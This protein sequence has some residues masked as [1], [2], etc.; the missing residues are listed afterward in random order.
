[1]LPAEVVE[2][3]HHQLQPVLAQR[4]VL[5]RFSIC[6]PELRLTMFHLTEAEEDATDLAL[7]LA[8]LLALRL[9]R[10]FSLPPPHWEVQESRLAFQLRPRATAHHHRGSTPPLLSLLFH[11]CVHH[12]LPLLLR[13]PVVHHLSRTHER[14]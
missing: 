12:R 4:H 3:T 10:I 14:T 7:T 5:R 8:M 13:Q 2:L 11:H 9:S 6:L 1:M